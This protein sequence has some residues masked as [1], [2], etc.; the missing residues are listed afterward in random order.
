MDPQSHDLPPDPSPQ[1][2]AWRDSVRVLDGIL[3]ISNL[4]GSVM[5]LDDILSR[6]V[7]ITS[8]LMDVPVCSLYLFDD[9]HQQIIMRSNVG[10]ESELIGRASFALGEGIP[11]WVASTGEVIATDDASAH[12]QY[13][14]L[15]SS[16]ELDVRAYLCAPLRIQ[17]EIV[18]VLTARKKE[19][20]SFTHDE[21]LFFETVCKQA[22][23][24]IEKARMH[25]QMIQAERLA[26]VAVSLTGVAHYIKNVLFTMQG[27]EHLVAQG[28]TQGD[29]SH[30]RE[31]WQVLKR[32]NRKIR[33][34]V[35]NILNYCR[36]SEPERQRVPLNA[37][38]DEMLQAIQE[39]A[40][41]R[42]VDLQRA[43]DPEI[44]DVWIEPESFYDALLNLI[45]NGMEAIGQDEGGEV[46]VS[47][48]RLDQR[49]QVRIEVSDS[50][51]GIPPENRAKIF[52]LFFTTRGKQGTGIGLAATRKIIEEHGGTIELDNHQ[53]RGT[54]FIIHLPIQPPDKAPLASA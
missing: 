1:G 51:H 25:E 26:A 40:R 52:N 11:G 49:N 16:L 22:A 9:D 33:G 4:V 48:H 32:A 18:G 5:L 39:T 6:I 7:H 14:P 34:L 43:L 54:R 29:L 12:P 3:E 41:E 44:G 10:F 20:H 23:I 15:S 2:P 38:I 31:G 28:L 8:N 53:E 50:G 35:E 37:M 21:V 17:E 46:V 27:G 47:T 36:Q 30:T 24:V 42:G 13:A 45:T 19:I